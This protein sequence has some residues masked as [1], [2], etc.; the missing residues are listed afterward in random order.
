MKTQPR[1]S[2][3]SG[4]EAVSDF[5]PPALDFVDLPFFAIVRNNRYFFR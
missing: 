3:V 5:L 1:T 4:D 2:R